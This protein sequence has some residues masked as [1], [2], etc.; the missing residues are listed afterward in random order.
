MVLVT[1]RF[2][3][4]LEFQRLVTIAIATKYGETRAKN[5]T[6]SAITSVLGEILTQ[7][8]VPKYNLCYQQTKLGHSHM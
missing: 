8:L 5:H 3:L 7:G 1:S 2:P 6:K 4:S